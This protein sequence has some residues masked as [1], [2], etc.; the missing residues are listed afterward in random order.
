MIEPPPQLNGV[1]FTPLM[2]TELPVMSEPKLAP[3][4]RSRLPGWPDF[5]ETFVTLGA[6]P[7]PPPET[8]NGVPLLG[9]PATFTTRF[10]LVTFGGAATTMLVALQ[11]TGVTVTPLNVT[12]LPA[13]LAPNPLPAIVTTV[14]ATPVAGEIESTIGT[15]TTA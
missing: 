6:E 12:V 14:P 8:V 15:E 1:Q 2:V 4:I 3:E 13:A 10:P 11:F 7:P 9:T 5:G